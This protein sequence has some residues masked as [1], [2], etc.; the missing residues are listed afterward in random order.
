MVDL[1]VHQNIVVVSSEIVSLFVCSPTCSRE[2]S[3]ATPEPLPSHSR[4]TP[5]PLPSHSGLNE[6]YRTFNG[7][8]GDCG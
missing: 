5:E 8:F 1:F 2:H 3:G 6:P 4:A 7:Q